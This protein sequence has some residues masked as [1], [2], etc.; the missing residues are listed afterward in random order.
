V[1]ATT[2]DLY[3]HGRGRDHNNSRGCASNHGRGYG[4]KGNFINKIEQ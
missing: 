2:S 1:N 3:N 4:Y